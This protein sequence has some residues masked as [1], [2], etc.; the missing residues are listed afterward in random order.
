V[1]SPWP[2]LRD[3]SKQKS[4]APETGECLQR[5]NNIGSE[6]RGGRLPVDGFSAGLDPAS[7]SNPHCGRK[8]GDAQRGRQLLTRLAQLQLQGECRTAVIAL[9]GSAALPTGPQRVYA[10]NR[11]CGFTCRDHAFRFW[12]KAVA[13]IGNLRCRDSQNISGRYFTGAAM[14]AVFSTIT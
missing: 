13:R 1:T 11:T 3:L 14:C 4:N 9:S 12:E 8:P 6:T 5:S 10:A 2:R 7:N